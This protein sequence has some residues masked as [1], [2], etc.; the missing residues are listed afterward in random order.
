MMGCLRLSAGLTVLSLGQNPQ[1]DH[2]KVATKQEAVSS[3]S[4]L[5]EIDTARRLKQSRCTKP[6][7]RDPESSS[8]LHTPWRHDV[9]REQSCRSAIVCVQLMARRQTSTWKLYV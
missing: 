5:Q 3:N 7:G 9:R 4:P 1:F 2:L 8:Q 6:L